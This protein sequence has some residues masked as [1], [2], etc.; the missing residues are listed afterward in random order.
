MSKFCRRALAALLTLALLAGVPAGVFALRPDWGYRVAS[1][2]RAFGADHPLEP[3]TPAETVQFTPSALTDTLL[4]VN[5]GHPLPADFAPTLTEYADTGLEMHPALADAYAAL[6]AA[7][8]AET[9]ETLLIRDA[10][11]SRAEQE[12]VY[13]AD[14]AVAAL[15]G[16]GEHEAA[17]ALDLCVSGYG[18]MAFLKTAAG[19]WV[20]DN[21]RQFGLIIR[22]PDGAEDETGIPYEPWHV[23][24][25]GAPHAEIITAGGLTLEGYIE[26]LTPGEF[27]RFGDWCISRQPLG[28]SYAVPA[29]AADVTA[30]PD[31]TG[32]T[33]LTC[34]LKTGSLSEGAV[35][36]AD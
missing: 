19:R 24:Y 35:G 30:A 20:S 33:I 14:P 16:T 36:A 12:A 17:L 10:Y 32:H 15:P 9:G 34:R 6:A 11:R 1:R 25:V 18:G 4:L 13:A 27:W 5:A 21:A 2:V 28:T 29:G 8:L 31:N 7:V 26:A 3:Y 22:Y 23:R